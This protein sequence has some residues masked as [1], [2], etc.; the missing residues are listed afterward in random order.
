VINVNVK[1]PDLERVHDPMIAGYSITMEKLR[2]IT[3]RE[4]PGGLL[5]GW[6]TSGVTQFRTP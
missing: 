6:E 3:L 5:S 4:V 1:N 2:D